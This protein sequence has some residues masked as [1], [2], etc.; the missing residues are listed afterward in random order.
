[1]RGQATR[2]CQLSMA[3]CVFMVM[4]RLNTSTLPAPCHESGPPVLQHLVAIRR[5]LYLTH[6]SLTA[7]SPPLPL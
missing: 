7:Q 4:P 3:D 5:G 6:L 2:P 1:M